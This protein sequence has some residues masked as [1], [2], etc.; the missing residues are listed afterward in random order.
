[1]FEERFVPRSADES[2]GFLEETGL[3]QKKKYLFEGL[4][5]GRFV[6]AWREGR[7]RNSEIMVQ[8]WNRGVPEGEPDGAGEG[9]RRVTRTPP[10][11]LRGDLSIFKISREN[12]QGAA[13]Y[14]R[15]SRSELEHL[16][17]TPLNREKTRES[18][19]ML[20]LLKPCT[21]GEAWA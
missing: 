10:H 17:R 4:Q 18:A 15:C 19:K 2:V 16:W 1:M 9:F 7:G 5:E 11:T 14:Q 6:R 12:R 13:K 3:T 8:V 20:K 21:G